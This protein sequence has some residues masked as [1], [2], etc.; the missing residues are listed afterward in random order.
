MAQL[1]QPPREL[2]GLLARSRD[3]DL[4]ET[5]C[6]QL[7][8]DGLRVAADTALEPG[9]VL[10]GDERRQRHA[11]VMSRHRREAPAA[12]QRDTAALGLDAAPGLG[13]VGCAHE[14]LLSRP[15]LE[16]ERTLTGLRQQLV[17][18]EAPSDL[19]LE[20]KPVEPAG[21]EDDGVEPALAALPQPRVD[22]AAQRLDRERRL[23]RKELRATPDRGRAD[24]QSRAAARRRRRGRR[25]D[26][27]AA[28]RRRR[29][30]R[31]CPSRSCPSRS[32][33][34]RRSGRRAAPPRAP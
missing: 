28:D 21:G 19:L 9:A 15:N 2:H 29:R 27:P 5:N 16:R 1:L 14:L 13:V 8:G 23:Q 31:P 11:V 24:P 22:V 26:P 12:D 10:V 18:L 33:R 4:H 34:R 25:A 17:G 7:A 6:E 3:D 30:D 32:A 20:T